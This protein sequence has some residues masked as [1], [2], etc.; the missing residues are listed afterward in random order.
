[1][2][3]NPRRTAF[4]DVLERM[5]AGVAIDRETRDA[6]WEARGAVTV[7]GR[8]LKATVVEG[9]EIPNLIDELPMVAALGALAE[10]T[11]VIRDARELRVKESDRIATMAEGLTALGA[12]VD[13]FEDGMAVTGPTAVRGGAAVDSHGDHRIAMALAVLALTA[14]APVEVRDTA[15]VATSYPGFLADMEALRV[16]E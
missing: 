1:V 8:A 13:V 14:R 16:R 3:L 2:G 6:S 11:T 7:R 15:C 10:G 4:L 12:R 5:G 9:D